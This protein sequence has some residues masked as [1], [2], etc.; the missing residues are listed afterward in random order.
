MRNWVCI[1]QISLLKNV[2]VSGGFE[3]GILK[4]RGPPFFSRL[5]LG[6]FFY[7][8]LISVEGGRVEEVEAREAFLN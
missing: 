1:L 7:H 6:G 3:K 4:D 8:L 5:S 2:D